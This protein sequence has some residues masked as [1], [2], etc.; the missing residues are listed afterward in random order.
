MAIVPAGEFVE[1][2]DVAAQAE[3]ERA[4]EQR[5]WL[6]GR[7]AYPVVVKCNLVVPRQIEGLERAPDS[8]DDIFAVLT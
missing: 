4:A 7:R 5:Q 8:C 2:D 6:E 3:A 1:R